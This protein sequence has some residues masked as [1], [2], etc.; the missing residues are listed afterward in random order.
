MTYLKLAEDRPELL[1]TKLV[2]NVVGPMPTP[3]QVFAPKEN[4]VEGEPY[5]V[6][7][8]LR[9]MIVYSDNRATEVLLN[10]LGQV[11]S[12]SGE[13]YIRETVYNLGVVSVN[14]SNEEFVTVKS[15]ASIFV[16]LYHASY[17]NKEMSEKALELLAQSEFKPGLRGG[18]PEGIALAHKFG[19][20]TY[21]GTHERQLHDCG[22]IY[23]PDN[24]YLLCVMTRGN[25]FDKLAEIIQA[26]SRM[27]YEEVGSRRI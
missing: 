12:K 19:E 5:S 1:E 13:G 11:L 17:L 10:Y 7:E 3:V 6:Y 26:I 15:Y 25:D 24:P 18:L 21:P 22:I 16:Q 27:V 20:R 2:F 9:R 8:L 23:Y 4:L 14:G